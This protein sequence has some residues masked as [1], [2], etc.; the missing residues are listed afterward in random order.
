MPILHAR[1]LFEFKTWRQAARLQAELAGLV[2]EETPSDFKPRWIC[3]LDVAYRDDRGFASAVV[4][5]L[6]YAKL[7]ATSHAVGLVSVGYLPGFLGFREGPIIMSAATNLAASVDVF[8]VDGH[9]QTHPRRFGSACQI[10]LALDK[11]T[12]GVAK[13][14][15]Y[16]RVEDDKVV[17][18]DGTLLGKVVKA[19][20]RK[21]Y[22]VSV[23]H[24]IALDD[25]ARLV[26]NCLVN[27]YPVP[28]REAHLEAVKLRRAR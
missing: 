13:S 18:P 10:G 14:R 24:R 16:G 2:I 1:D 9:G 15:F 5:D 3:G 27:G 17:G 25:A 7:V 19:D 23:G 26:N 28:L 12:I 4:W 8:M 11:P 21:H 6:E 22:Y 20:E